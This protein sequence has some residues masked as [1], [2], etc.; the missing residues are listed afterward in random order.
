MIHVENKVDG[1]NTCQLLLVNI[2]LQGVRESFDHRQTG[3]VRRNVIS[4][5][6][7]VSEEETHHAWHS[8]DE[9]EGILS[10]IV[11]A[12]PHAEGLDADGKP[13]HGMSIA[14]KC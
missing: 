8:S 2:E 4:P 3:I 10:P 11:L 9:V 1:E 7:T 13:I 6:F 12:I 14:W 5:S